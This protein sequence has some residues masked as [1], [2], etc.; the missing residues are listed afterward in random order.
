MQVLA[1]VMGFVGRKLF[2]DNLPFA[3]LGVS[4]LFND[5]FYAIGL[6]DIGFASILVFNLYKPINENDEESVKWYVSAFKKIYSIIAGIMMVVSFAIMPFVYTAFKVDYGNK[7]VVYAIYIIQ[8]FT[9]LSKYFF[10]HK[11]NIIVV[12]QQKWK[13]NFITIGLDIVIFIFKAIAMTVFKSYILYLIAILLHGLI[14][15]LINVYITDKMYPYLKKLPKVRLKEIKDR[16]IIKQSRNFL[17]HTFYNFVYYTTDSFIISYKL[18]TSPLGFIDNYTMLIRI[19]DEF[20]STIIGSLR[21]S[22]ANFLHV[23]KDVQGLLDIYKMTNIFN[24]VMTS[25]AIVGLYSMINKFIPLWIGEQYV[26]PS[27]LSTLL[28]INLA[29]DLVFR[30]LENIYSIKGYV[31]IERWPIFISAIVKLVSALLLVDKMGISGIFIGTLLGKVVFWWGKLYYVT[32]DVFLE[33]KWK[34]VVDLLTMVLFLA[35][36]AITINYIAELVYPIISSLYA[37]V[38]RGVLVCALIL[39]SDVLFFIKSP[40]LKQLISLLVSTIKGFRKTETNA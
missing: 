3:L 29:I 6:I 39:I 38:L 11:T 37:F 32:N 18:G 1:L 31:F 16:G 8:L 27:I 23:E 19:F 33:E 17:Y 28:I 13:I 2:V 20:I 15:N 26:I 4:K 34:T 5:F 40:Y 24:Y 25:F 30:P 21:D 10:I 22:F 9:C 12:S 14:I 36:Q 7:Y 35:I